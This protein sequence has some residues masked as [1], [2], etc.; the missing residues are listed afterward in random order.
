MPAREHPARKRACR[1]RPSRQSEPRLVRRRRHHPTL[2]L[3]ARRRHAAAIRRPHH[4]ST[5]RSIRSIPST[6]QPGDIVGIGIHTGN[7]LRGYEVGR[8]AR[9][10][11]AIGRVRRHPR[12]ALSRRSA[13]ARRRAQ[14]GERR[15][16]RR[17][18]PPSSP[19]APP[20]S[21]A[22][23]TTADASAPTR[24]LP[25]RWDLLPPDRYMWASVQTVRGCPKHCSF[26]SVWRT[27]GQAPRMRGVDRVVQR[28]RR[29]AA[30]RI[31][32]HRA[33]RRQL[34]SGL[35]RPISNRRGAGSIQHACT[36]WKRSARNASN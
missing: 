8:D 18:G 34:L 26:C 25:A 12:D 13:R 31:P 10:R 29:T 5:R 3:R 23:S 28:N 33:R 36:N 4:L 15:R 2:A 16:R 7:A 27:D 19:T 17:S 24:S 20:A 21:P 9:A 14:R 22:A 30:P 32:V 11:G 1:A 35:A 6:I